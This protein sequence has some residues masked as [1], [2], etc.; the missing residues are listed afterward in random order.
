MMQQQTSWGN[1]PLEDLASLPNFHAPALSY[2][3]KQIAFFSDT[4]GQIE[5]YIME[6]RSGAIAKQVGAGEMP[7]TV[8]TSPV[9]TRDDDYILFAKDNG[10]DEQFNIWRIEIAT[11]VTE[12]L[13][14]NAD[15]QEYPIE[16]SPDN[17]NLLVAANLNGQMNLF[18]LNLTTHEYSQLTDYKNPVGSGQFSPD[19]SQIVYNANESDDFKNS[20]IYLM[21][22]DGSNKRQILHISTGSSE[23]FSNWSEDG[24]R[25]SVNTDAFGKNTAGVYHLK[26]GEVVWLTPHDKTVYAGEFSPDGVHLLVAE[27]EDASITPQVYKEVHQTDPDAI[28]KVDLELPPGMS[29]A[30]EW[31]D[32]ERFVINLNTD[33]TRPE[34]RDYRLRDGASDVLIAAEYGDID[35][36]LFAAHEYITYESFDGLNIPALL[37][38]PKDMESGKKYPA[39]VNVHGGPTAQYFRGFN[40]FVQFMADNGYI[41]IQPNVRGSTGYGVE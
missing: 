27:N 23:R 29:Y 7:K 19:G 2:D 32:N 5:L 10:G 31:L 36:S 17:K 16:V 40:P 25:L 14:D 41:V 18:A 21:H 26:G 20:D 8:R 39:I 12:Q 1:I 22:A 37:Y 38:R 15:A 33:V 11:G 30:T 24:A 28:K 6:A 4:S 3:R 35:P 9:W 13:T 34:L